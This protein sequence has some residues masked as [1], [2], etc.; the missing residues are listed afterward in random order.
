MTEQEPSYK[1]ALQKSAVYLSDPEGIVDK[2]VS[3]ANDKILIRQNNVIIIMLAQLNSRITDLERMLQNKASQPSSSKN[4]EHD[5]EELTKTLGNISL[6]TKSTPNI[7]IAPIFGQ[8]T[9]EAKPTIF[10]PPN[11]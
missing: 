10:N 1:L 8:V 9:P 5:I 6:G 3:Q 11:E 7:P 2:D 4:L